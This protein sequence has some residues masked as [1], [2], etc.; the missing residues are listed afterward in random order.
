MALISFTYFHL[1]Q[2]RPLN[3]IWGNKIRK[4]LLNSKS[5]LYHNRCC[6]YAFSIGYFSI[7]C[8]QACSFIM[9]SIQDLLIK[10]KLWCFYFFFQQLFF[11]V[12]LFCIEI[13]LCLKAKNSLS[14]VPFCVFLEWNIT[15][16]FNIQNWFS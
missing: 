6:V 16:C 14:L 12:L 11:V 4:S 10:F 13:Q 5:F 3:I 7:G 8:S 9:L 1:G 15:L 2:K